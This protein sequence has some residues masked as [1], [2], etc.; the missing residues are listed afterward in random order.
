MQRIIVNTDPGVDDAMALLYVLNSLDIRLEAIIASYGN[1][2]LEVATRNILEILRVARA[3]SA[4]QVALGADS[5]LR[6]IKEVADAYSEN[7]LGGWAVASEVT[8]GMVSEFAA[9]D[10][11]PSLA[12]QHHNEVALVTIAPMTNAAL[13]LRKNPLGFRMIKEIIMMG[14]SLRSRQYHSHG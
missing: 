3:K 11:I 12:Q 1:V 10:L 8:P 13:A 2:P 6:G 14:G 9:S 5:P 4:P 7:G